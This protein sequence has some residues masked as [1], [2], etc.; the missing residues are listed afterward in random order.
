MDEIMKPLELILG[1]GAIIGSLK[2]GTALLINGIVTSPGIGKYF[3]A[4]MGETEKKP[5]YST[6]E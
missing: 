4:L 6:R 3:S 2:I 1:D 5:D